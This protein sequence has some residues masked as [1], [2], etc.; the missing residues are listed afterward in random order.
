MTVLSC[1]LA[2]LLG[3]FFGLHPAMFRAYLLTGS[4]FKNHS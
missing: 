2:L 4:A 3:F 1:V